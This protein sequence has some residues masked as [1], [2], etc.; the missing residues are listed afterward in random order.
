MLFFDLQ[1][2]FMV[3]SHHESPMAPDCKI[4][5]FYVC[6]AIVNRVKDTAVVIVWNMRRPTVQSYSFR[7]KRDVI[8]FLLKWSKKVM[9]KMG[10]IPRQ[11]VIPL[12]QISKP[13]IK[14]YIYL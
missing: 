6:I 2:M 8:S 13:G 10:L 9:W 12:F 3:K 5:H 1:Y 7:I 11:E 4:S 14:K